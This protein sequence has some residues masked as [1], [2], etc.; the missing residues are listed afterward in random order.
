M[1]SEEEGQRRFGKLLLYTKEEKTKQKN[2]EALHAGTDDQTKEQV[3]VAL[4][5]TR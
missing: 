5:A 3:S 4:P 1:R 2:P